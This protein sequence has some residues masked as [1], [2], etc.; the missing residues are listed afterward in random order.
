MNAQQPLHQIGTHEEAATGGC[1]CNEHDAD[2]PTLD[3]TA[4]PHAIRHATIFGAL[5]T[6]HPGF[7]LDLLAPHDPLPLLAQIKDAYKESMVWSYVETGPQV[8]RL[9]FTH[10]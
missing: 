1:G 6:L 9:R 3:A 7:S 5:S 4:I 10:Q 8:W 2:I